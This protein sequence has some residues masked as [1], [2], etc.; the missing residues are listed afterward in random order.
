M[1][2]KSFRYLGQHDRV[3]YAVAAGKYDA[4]ALSETVLNRY[5]MSSRRRVICKFPAPQ[6]VWLARESIE[7]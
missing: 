4:G 6:K 2:L 3:A 1:D 7:D 5:E